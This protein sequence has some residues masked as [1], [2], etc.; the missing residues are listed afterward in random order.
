[1]LSPFSSLSLSIS[2]Y[3]SPKQLQNCCTNYSF[4]VHLILIS[5]K[6]LQICCIVCSYTSF[7]LSSLF[8]FL[9]SILLSFP[10]P[11]SFP[12][13]SPSFSPRCLKTQPLQ[14]SLSLY[15]LPPP[16]FPRLY[17]PLPS[18]RLKIYQ[19]LIVSWFI[20]T[21]NLPKYSFHLLRSS[22]ES[23]VGSS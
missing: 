23:T 5:Q 17:H 19:L 22:E 18:R 12:S 7:L 9:S 4:E 11:L 3:S 20:L 13:I 1:M 2:I 16:V 15:A 21:F 6:Y 8:L 10:L 14:S